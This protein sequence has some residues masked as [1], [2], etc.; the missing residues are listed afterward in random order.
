M[1][2]NGAIFLTILPEVLNSALSINKL[3]HETKMNWKASLTK[4]KKTN[5]KNIK[6]KN[7][8]KRDMQY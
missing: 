4:F 1:L 3:A 5:K 2:Q 7:T 6:N 8:N